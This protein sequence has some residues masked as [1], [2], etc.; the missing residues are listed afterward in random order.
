[1]TIRL[2]SV[3]QWENQKLVSQMSRV[4]S[5]HLLFFSSFYQELIRSKHKKKNVTIFIIYNIY[6]ILSGAT[7]SYYNM[8]KSMT[9]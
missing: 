2:E 9:S 4:D 5:R 6:N 1:M 3:A 7:Y 8:Y